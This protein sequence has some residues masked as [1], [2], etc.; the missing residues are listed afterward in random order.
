METNSTGW[1]AE[2]IALGAVV[3]GLVG[4][5][6]KDRLGVAHRL[7]KLETRQEELIKK[8]DLTNA[9]LAELNRTLR[10][11]LIEYRHEHPS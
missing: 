11:I 10:E 7:T 8:G 4:A 3:C 2:I 6:I 5:W 1:L 9:E